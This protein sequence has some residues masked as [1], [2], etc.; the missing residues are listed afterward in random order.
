M[1]ALGV[2]LGH[3][4]S[5]ALVQDGRIVA[6]VA[7]ER[8]VRIKH[9]AGLPIHSIDYCLQSRNLTI[10]DIDVIAVPAVSFAPALHFLFDL[11]GT[12]QHKTRKRL[13]S[14]SRARQFSPGP[15]SAAPI[16]LKNFPVS[17]RT[18]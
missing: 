5:A 10:D 18:E 4:S 16:Y 17:P 13:E 8:F 6:D 1:N 15:Q 11:K 12:K 14:L 7:E 3:D 9:Y 2:H